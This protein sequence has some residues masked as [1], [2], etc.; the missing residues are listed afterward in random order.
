MMLERK[1]P[2]HERP[3][4]ARGRFLLHRAYDTKGQQNLASPATPLTR[5]CSN[6]D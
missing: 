2:K 1:H 6:S 4:S 3:R 5:G